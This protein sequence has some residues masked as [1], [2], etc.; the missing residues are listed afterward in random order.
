LFDRHI[1]PLLCAIL[2]AS[3]IASG[4]HRRNHD[5]ARPALDGADGAKYELGGHRF[6][7]RLPLSA[8]RSRCK[9]CNACTGILEA[10]GIQAVKLP[11]WSPNLNAHLER[12]HRSVKEECLSKMILFGEASLREALSNYVLH[13]HSERN[14][15][16][17]DNSILF[18][19]PEDRVGASTGKTQT[20]E[21]LGGLLK[22]YY[23]EAA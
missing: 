11:A 22:F 13:F 10:V 2:H 17:K 15:Q 12:W 1:N 6:S 4:L 21:R 3:G 7:Q 8:A 14:H 16:G 9:I 20:R 19:R 23:R 5:V 18:P